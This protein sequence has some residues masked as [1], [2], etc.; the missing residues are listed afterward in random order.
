MSKVFF[1]EYVFLEGSIG[2]GKSTILGMIKEHLG[3][4]VMAEKEPVYFWKKFP[5]ENGNVNLL[6]KFYENQKDYSF[7]FQTLVVQSL[8]EWQLI[9]VEKNPSML[10]L[11]RSIDAAVE[12]F[13]RHLRNGEFI[14]IEQ[15]GVLKFMKNMIQKVQPL[16]NYDCCKVIYLRCKPEVCNER[17]KMHGWEEEKSITVEFLQ[18]L[19]CLYESLYERRNQSVMVINAA[20]KNHHYH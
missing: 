11:E 17:I 7:A 20:T 14:T 13:T 2:S 19:N 9:A 8:F 10:V 15:E 1:L 16:F 12:V 6:E 3:D 5:T 18:K 4:V